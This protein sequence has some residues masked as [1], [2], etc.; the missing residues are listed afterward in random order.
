MQRKEE[1]PGDKISPTFCILPWIHLNTWPNGNVY[2]CCLTDWREDIGNMKDN[3]LEELWNGDIMKEIRRFMLEGKK[4][5]SCRKCFQQEDYGLDS[6]RESSNRHYEHHIDTITNNTTPDGYNNDFK[7]LYWD[8]RF[9][10]LCNFKCRMCGSFLSSK[11]YEDEVKIFGGSVLPQAII[12]V[13]DYSKKGIKFYLDKFI[14]EVEEIYFAGGEPLLMDEHYYILEELTKKKNFDVRLR[15]NTNLGFLKFKKWDNLEL[16]KPFKERSDL[17]VNIFASIDAYGPRAEYS[18]KGTKWPTIENN[19]KR[20][21]EAGFN[22]HISC[23]TNIF[24]VFHVPDLVDEMIRI[25]VPYYSIQLNNVLTNP[26]YYHIN[27][28]PKELKDKV[29]EKYNKHLD[30]MESHIRDEFIPKYESIFNFMNEEVDGD[31]EE[32]RVAFKEL[33][34]KLDKGREENFEEVFPELKEWFN[35]IRKDEDETWK[36]IL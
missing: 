19:I 9:S 30:S 10:N 14:D 21:I 32:I 17:N 7:L 20:L 4:H 1:K 12:N 31:V 29:T 3:T 35:S 34:V 36:K 18:R 13:D 25:G 26:N 8:F 16:W 5:H 24:N 22:F 23:T 11:W 28:L 6:T 33:T 2:P 27:I 15:Y